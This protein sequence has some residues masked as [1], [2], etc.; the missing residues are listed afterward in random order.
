MGLQTLREKNALASGV[1]ADFT[2]TLNLTSA[3]APGGYIARFTIRDHVGQNL[4][5]HEVRFDLP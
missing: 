2:N 3:A 5:T 4:K 1:P